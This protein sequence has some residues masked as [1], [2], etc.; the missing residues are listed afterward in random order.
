MT[1]TV[2]SIVWRRL[3]GSL[4]EGTLHDEVLIQRNQEARSM[5]SGKISD[6]R[7][8]KSIVAY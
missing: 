7:C 6:F 1:S 4:I 5:S 2:D 3:I 8:V